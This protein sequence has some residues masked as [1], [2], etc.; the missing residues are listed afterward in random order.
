Y[1]YGYT[2]RISPEAPVPVI[3]VT[4][5]LDRPGGAGSVAAD[6]VAL[7]ADVICV[8][9]IG[10]DPPGET[11]KTLLRN[12]K[13]IN[14]DGLIELPNRPTTVKQRLIGLAQHRHQ[15]QLMR[16]DEEDTSPIDQQTQDRLF[17]Q[18]E[19]L[20][21]KANVVCLEDYHKGLLTGDLCRGIIQSANDAGIPVLIDPAAQSDFS[22]YAGA[23]LLKPNR[24]ELALA[25]GCE[26]ENPDHC[27]EPCRYLAQTHRIQNLVITL[28]KSG[29]FLYQSPDPKNDA[30]ESARLIPTKTRDV[31]D[32][33]GAGDMVFAAL[34]F[35]IG[36]SY[37]NTQPPTLEEIVAL[38][39]V[40]G[41]LEVERYGSVGIN[42]QE[43]IAEL[44][45]ESHLQ[46]PKL[47]TSQDLAGELESHRRQNKTIVFTNGCFDILHTGHIRLLNFAKEQ[48]DIL[49]VA[50]N[51][52][53]SVKA[54]K[55]PSRPINNQNDRAELIAALQAVDYVVIYDQ[56]TPQQLIETLTPDY[57][58]KGADWTGD[59]V[60]QQ[61]VEDHG[62][63]V[64]LFPLVEQKSSTQI[65][66]QLQSKKP[67]EKVNPGK[68]P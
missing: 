8:A 40:A 64:K 57:L 18:I 48:G 41:S 15:Q 49:I 52:D 54:L 62:G 39:N 24:R 28:D 7:G 16:L 38:A 30:T 21:P 33:T 44:L 67:L 11:L 17:A 10:N 36:G 32:V 29:A 19:K 51:S 31:Y 6:L 22:K 35:L 47:R 3:N 2:D 13:K 25:A 60:G 4:Q 50:L 65:I 37:Q 58:I 27:L 14:L 61:W 66:E 56:Q 68:S 23:W 59:V 9:T 55:G 53:Q 20:I 43:I 63:S 1:L 45:K 26:I 34:A 42:R 5:R 12:L 46:T